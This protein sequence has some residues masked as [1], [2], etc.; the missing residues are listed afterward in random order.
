MRVGVPKL[1]RDPLMVKRSV[2]KEEILGGLEDEKGKQPAFP[3]P[4]W[5]LANMLGS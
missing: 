5:V 3:L 2:G 1:R 4:T